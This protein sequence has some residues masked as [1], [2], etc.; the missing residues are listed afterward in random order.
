MK[1]SCENCTHIAHDDGG[2]YCKVFAESI[3]D[4]VKVATDCGEFDDGMV[5]LVVGHPV[6]VHGR[7]STNTSVAVA[8]KPVSLSIPRL[9]I[10]PVSAFVS[11]ER[12]HHVT[13][14][15][16]LD[17]FGKDDY[18]D[19]LVASVVETLR[20]EFGKRVTGERTDAH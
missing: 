14:E 20:L 8:P 12:E 9:G 17:Y 13:V 18:G 10:V 2:L 15:V 7:R 4:P 11:A 19:K 5:G 3:H 6:V 16:G 1:F